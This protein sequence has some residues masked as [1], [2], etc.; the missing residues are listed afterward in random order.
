MT[1]C[2][3]C[4]PPPPRI[5]HWR[6][7]SRTWNASSRILCGVSHLP[8]TTDPDQVTCP[9]CRDLMA[10]TTPWQ[11]GELEDTPGLDS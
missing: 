6:S 4:P 3:P 7:I 1:S 2:R 9:A 11:R 8:S 5:I 10:C